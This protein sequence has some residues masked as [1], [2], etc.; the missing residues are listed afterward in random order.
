[1]CL[2]I[3]VKKWSSSFLNTQTNKIE[4]DDYYSESWIGLTICN[5]MN[6]LHADNMMELMKSEEYLI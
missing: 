6:F 2:D 1:M 3:E 5:S 4:C